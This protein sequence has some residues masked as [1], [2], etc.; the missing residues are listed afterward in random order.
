MHVFPGVGVAAFFADPLS[1]KRPKGP[2]TGVLG[3]SRKDA[4][5][6]V[7]GVSGPSTAVCQLGVDISELGVSCC[8]ILRRKAELLPGEIDGA[9]LVAVLKGCWRW[10]PAATSTS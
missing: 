9:G 10:L 1:A 4:T 2:R 8:K 7:S 3:V 5:F 6:A